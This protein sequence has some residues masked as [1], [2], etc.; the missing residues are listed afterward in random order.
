[1]DFVFGEVKLV[2]VYLA[3]CNTVKYISHRNI[4]GKS[5]LK[6]FQVELFFFFI[7]AA[8]FN[9]YFLEGL[10]ELDSGVLR[11]VLVW[12]GLGQLLFQNLLGTTPGSKRTRGPLSLQRTTNKLLSQ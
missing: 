1:M 4:V 12:A 7:M 6:S 11:F 9:E 5:I 3:H 2:C 10:L 8:K